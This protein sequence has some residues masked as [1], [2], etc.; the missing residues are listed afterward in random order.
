MSL[1]QSILEHAAALKDLAAAIREAAGGVVNNTAP[2]NTKPAATVKDKPTP[3]TEEEEE[4][5]EPVYWLNSKKGTFGVCE[6]E[7]AY[8]KLKK[9]DK[10]A[11]KTTK[12][13]YDAK[14]KAAAE[15]EAASGGDDD[16]PEPTLKDL[17]S[18]A[19]KYLDKEA[20]PEKELAKR[21]LAVKEIL[22]RFDNPEKVTAIPKEHWALTI[23]ILQRLDAGQ[24]FD[25]EDAEFEA[26]EA[27]SDEVEI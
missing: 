14:V 4:E 27:G 26:I 24:K 18:A 2:V 21:R 11:V 25:I 16:V 1:E 7:A 6:S 13:K 3:E 12:A 23:N 22:A 15:A 17:A 9:T 20:H 8:T 19:Q 10:D 5:V